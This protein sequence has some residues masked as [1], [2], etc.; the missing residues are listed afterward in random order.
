MQMGGGEADT[1]CIYRI[2]VLM[3]ADILRN[4]SCRILKD[5]TPSEHLEAP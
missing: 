2:K 4:L 1:S 3:F 5:K